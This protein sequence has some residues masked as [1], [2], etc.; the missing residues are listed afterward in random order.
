[1]A[2]REQ[3]TYHVTTSDVTDLIS[4]QISDFRSGHQK[5][6]FWEWEKA[7]FTDFPHFR[8]CSLQ[9]SYPAAVTDKYQLSRLNS[10]KISPPLFCNVLDGYSFP[11]P[12]LALLRNRKIHSLQIMHIIVIVSNTKTINIKIKSGSHSKDLAAST[13]TVILSLSCRKVCFNSLR[14]NQARNIHMKI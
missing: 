6:P 14:L 8:K 11:I 1:M 10:W 12:I 3:I 2:E 4:E 9:L 7:T 5:S 13:L